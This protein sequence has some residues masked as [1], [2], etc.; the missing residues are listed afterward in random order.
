MRASVLAALAAA[1]TLVTRADDCDSWTLTWWTP[2]W[3][4][5]HYA[6]HELLANVSISASRHVELHP[7]TAL[8]REQ[9]GGVLPFVA[10]LADVGIAGLFCAGLFCDPPPPPK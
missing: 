8:H 7:V 2:A 5:L 10:V 4:E 1:L 6:E 3:R 9:E